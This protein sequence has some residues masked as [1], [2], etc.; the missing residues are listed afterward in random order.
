M[1][2]Y[3]QA[4]AEQSKDYILGRVNESTDKLVSSL[5]LGYY[6]AVFTIAITL[7][8]V[9]I[10]LFAMIVLIMVYANIITVNKAMVAFLIWFVF[11]KVMAGIFVI[12]TYKYAGK[13]IKK[14]GEVYKNF[15]ASEKIPV[16]IDTAAGIYVKTAGT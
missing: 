3:T 4:Q 16:I 2:V 6:S 9:M 1:S 11:F 12:Y 13:R 10:I 5:T 7:V 15:I 8:M 14:A